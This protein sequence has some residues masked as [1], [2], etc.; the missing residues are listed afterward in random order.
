MDSI[1]P[2][3]VKIQEQFRDHVENVLI[4]VP[5]NKK[6]KRIC[7]NHVNHSCLG[8]ANNIDSLIR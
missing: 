2:A 8:L 7:G 5:M 3:D 6:Q 4:P 1:A